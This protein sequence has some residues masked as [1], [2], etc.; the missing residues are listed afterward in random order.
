M[1]CIVVINVSI[2]QSLMSYDAKVEEGTKDKP[3]RSRKYPNNKS[4]MPVKLEEANSS[5]TNATE[6]LCLFLRLSEASV[7]I[8]SILVLCIPN[9]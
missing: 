6:E 7:V 8:I 4:Y 1:H 2:F 5:L 3:A 9:C